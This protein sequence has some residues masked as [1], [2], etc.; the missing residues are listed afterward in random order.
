MCTSV[1]FVRNR[2]D[3]APVPFGT[4]NQLTYRVARILHDE[5]RKK[6]NDGDIKSLCQM[7]ISCQRPYRSVKLE[8]GTVKILYV[9]VAGKCPHLPDNMTHGHD[10]LLGGPLFQKLN[11]KSLKLPANR[12]NLSDVFF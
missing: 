8:I 1:V 4:V 7:T 9:V 10:M 12:Q 11:S 5:K 2:L 3:N 6:R